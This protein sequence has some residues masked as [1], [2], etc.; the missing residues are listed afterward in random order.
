MQLEDA[1][2]LDA[3]SQEALRRRAVRLVEEKSCTHQYAAEAVGVARQTVSKWVSACRRGGPSA[4][5]SHKRGR[6]STSQ[7]A[8][9]GREEQRTQQMIRDKCPNQLKLSFALWTAGAVHE[10]IEREWGKA[11]ALSTVQLYLR[12]WGFTPQKPLIRVKERCP[13]RIQRWLATEYPAIVRRAKKAGGLILWGDETGVCNQ[14]QIGRSYAPQGQTPVLTKTTKR[15]STS[16]ISV[17]SNR[18]EL[19]FMVYEGALNVAA[20]LRFLRR[21]IRGRQQKLFLIVDNLKVHHAYKVQA[22]VAQHSSALELCFLPPYAPEFNPDEY[23][24]NDLKQHLSRR[25]KPK[26]KPSLMKQVRATMQA[27]QGQPKRTRSYFRAPAVRY[28]A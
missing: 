10:L 24:N 7:K 6:D 9:T 2:K 16:M 26:D 20:F 25:P 13:V 18:G 5:Q 3:S 4:L 19:R 11:L 22:W 8:L 1:R 15:F 17:V 28:A 23:L 21:L 27:F 14:D 12:R